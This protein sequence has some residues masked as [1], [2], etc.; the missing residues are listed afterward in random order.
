[1]HPARFPLT[2]VLFCF[3]KPPTGQGRSLRRQT[4]GLTP[5]GQPT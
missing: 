2:R 3:A 5:G 1:M 4:P